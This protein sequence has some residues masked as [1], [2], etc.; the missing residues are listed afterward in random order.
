MSDVFDAGRVTFL[1]P[2]FAPYVQTNYL[3]KF[4]IRRSVDVEAI[5]E[6][7]YNSLPRCFYV[8]V[9]IFSSCKRCSEP[10]LFFITS[11]RNAL[12]FPINSLKCIKEMQVKTSYFRDQRLVLKRL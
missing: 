6:Y 2:F 8:S 12:T 3:K 1:F 9:F 10:C 4:Y 11:R 5:C 7:P